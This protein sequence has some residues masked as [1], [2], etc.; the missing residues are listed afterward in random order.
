MSDSATVEFMAQLRKFGATLTEYVSTN[1]GD[2]S[3]K[4]FIDVD[5]NIYSISADTKSSQKF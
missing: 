4:G 5:Q 3:I 2:W 1:G